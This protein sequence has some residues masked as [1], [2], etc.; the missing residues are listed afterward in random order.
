MF[1]NSYLD[2]AYF[3]GIAAE[4]LPTT[5]QSILPD[6]PMWVSTHPAANK[7]IPIKIHN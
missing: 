6:Y 7:E 5:H 2:E 3:L 4:A 1:L